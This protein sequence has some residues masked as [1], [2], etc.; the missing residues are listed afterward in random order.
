MQRSTSNTPLR[1]ALV[2]CACALCACAPL[3][4]PPCPDGAS[5]A[6]HNGLC[7]NLPPDHNTATAVD[8]GA[9]DTTFTA[10]ADVD[11]HTVEDVDANL[12]DTFE[13]VPPSCEPFDATVIAAFVNPAGADGA[14]EFVVVRV[15]VGRE[16]NLRIIGLNGSDG[17]AWL[18]E[19][20]PVA[21]DVRGLARIGAG[22]IL[23]ICMS[24]N[25]CLQNGPDALTLRGCAGTL[26]DAVIYGD[27]ALLSARLGDA[28]Q[29]PMPGESELLVS[30]AADG[31]WF[32]TPGPLTDEEIAGLHGNCTGE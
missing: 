5:R 1:S 30:C 14:D 24:G 15:P 31:S 27:N 26:L 28:R 4:R 10:D 2:L 20:Y 22:G 18:D 17:S 16:V 21:G 12:W 32:A 7:A 9:A 3:T 19:S 13:D 23:P 6:A 25:G 8:A 11:E 29:A